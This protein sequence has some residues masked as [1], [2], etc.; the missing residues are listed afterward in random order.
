[1]ETYTNRLTPPHFFAIGQYRVVA[2]NCVGT[3]ESTCTVTEEVLPPV[4]E[5]RLPTFS[6]KEEGNTLVLEAKVDGSPPPEITW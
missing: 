3:T 1:M 2:M 4:I 6:K 5:S